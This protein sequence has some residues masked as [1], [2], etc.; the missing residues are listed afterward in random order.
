M[1]DLLLVGSAGGGAGGGQTWKIGAQQGG[2]DVE[3]IIG[4]E[5]GKR[6]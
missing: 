3:F 6:T 5:R 1:S 4:G 2:G